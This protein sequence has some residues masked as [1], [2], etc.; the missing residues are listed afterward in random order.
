MIPIKTRGH[1]TRRN[2]WTR[3]RVHNRAAVRRPRL[4]ALRDPRGRHLLR[5]AAAIRRNL[6]EPEMPHGSGPVT[7]LRPVRRPYR[8]MAHTV[9]SDVGKHAAI[10][11]VDV[12]I[13]TRSFYFN[14]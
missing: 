3:F 9:G 6:P 1:D 2:S 11:I 13:M 5:R 14:C 12:Q 8:P 7:E 4:R 10:E